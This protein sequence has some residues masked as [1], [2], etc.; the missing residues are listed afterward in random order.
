[1]S[2]ILEGL[3]DILWGWPV[4]LMILAAGAY[5]SY[6]SCFFQLF[7]PLRW[8][9][10]ALGA[11]GGEAG[12]SGRFRAI[13][14]ALAGS[15]GTGNIVGVAAAI[16]VG[17]PGAIFWMCASAVLGMMTVYTENL[18]AARIRQKGDAGSGP[19]AYIERAGRL[20]GILAGVYALGCALSSLAMGNM[21]QVNALAAACKDLGLPV[22]GVA[23]AVGVLIFFV[24][25]GGLEAAGRLT[26]KLVPVM[27]VLFFA[28]S[29]GVLWV[30]R[31]ALPDAV[32]S[33]FDGA[34]TLRAGA[35]GTAGMLI[36]MKAG[37]SRGVF[38]N[39]AGLGSSA[40]AYTDVQGHTPEEIGCMGIFQVF[41]DTIIMCTVTGLCI[42]C[43]C[44]PEA[45]DGAEL[46]FFA[47]RSALGQAGGT[48]VTLCTAL[49][50]LAT[51]IAWCCYGKE[52]M[53]YLT[54]GRG[55]GIYS[56]A[57]ALAAFAGCL[58]PLEEVFRL[59]DAM[60]GLMAIPN[61]ITLFCLAREH[62]SA[63][64]ELIN[65]AK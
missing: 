16:T 9:R 37:V 52:G 1:M 31:A 63:G 8:L 2:G 34:F 13:S 56:A 5:F 40:F 28:A 59:G 18:F 49:F 21:V 7:H 24:A 11:G 51:V 64:N 43:S 17:G 6:E 29:L 46:T 14:T 44:P 32:A 26:E 65:Q 12:K 22:R 62:G 35:G 38:T 20:G 33:I 25:R 57:A 10:A 50:A 61:I 55:A 48:A 23:V 60:N 39:E 3:R 47:Y 54:K 45:M 27:T 53:L 42:L 30:H 4:L 19:L 41:A 36:A 15:I 58:L